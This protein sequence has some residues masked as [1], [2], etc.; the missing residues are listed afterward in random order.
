MRFKHTRVIFWRPVA[1]AAALC[2][3]GCAGEN[4][5]APQDAATD[6]GDTARREQ[7]PSDAAPEQSTAYRCGGPSGTVGFE[8]ADFAAPEVQCHWQ[9]PNVMSTPLV[10][11]VDGDGKPEVIFPAFDG[12]IHVISG[13]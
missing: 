2:A 10:A 3:S 6:A 7:V 5:T 9:G 4:A 11:D 1:A 13:T 12:N 8:V